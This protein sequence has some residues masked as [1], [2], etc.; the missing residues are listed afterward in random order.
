GPQAS[1]AGDQ[2]GPKSG[3]ALVEDLEITFAPPFAVGDDVDA[4][5]LLEGDGERNGLVAGSL[6]FVTRQPAGK[7]LLQPIQEP[8][9]PPQAADH[10]GGEQREIHQLNRRER[11]VRGE[12]T[13]TFSSC[14]RDLSALSASSAVAI[15]GFN[16]FAPGPLNAAH[17][18]LMNRSPL[19]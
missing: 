17:F 6:P 5:G 10:S 12:A 15:Q 9:R 18:S 8:R 19:V 16:Y 1:A 4:G 7:I 3:D 2:I 11:R 13:G 14:L